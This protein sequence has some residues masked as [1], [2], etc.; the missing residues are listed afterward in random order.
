MGREEGSG[1]GTRVYL[2]QIHVDIW[3]NQYN[4]VKLKNKKKEIRKDIIKIINERVYDDF[5]NYENQPSN[6]TVLNFYFIFYFFCNFYFL[7]F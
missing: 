1:W 3:Q 2:W 4:I 7:F 6:Y 5:Q